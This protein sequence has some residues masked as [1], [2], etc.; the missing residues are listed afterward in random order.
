MRGNKENKEMKKPRDSPFHSDFGF[1]RVST[2]AS[3][4]MTKKNMQPKLRNI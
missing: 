3:R 1:A 2:G 4:T